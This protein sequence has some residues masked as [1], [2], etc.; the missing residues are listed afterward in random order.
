MEKKRR[1]N[2]YLVTS[3]P[4]A[5]EE[6]LGRARKFFQ[7][8]APQWQPLSATKIYIQSNPTFF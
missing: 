6:R 3:G 8:T 7:R 5:C 2:I 1:I 4:R